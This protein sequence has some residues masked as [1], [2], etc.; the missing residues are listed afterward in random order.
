MVRSIVNI[1]SGSL[2]GSIGPIGFIVD[3]LDTRS[4]ANIID[5]S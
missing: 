2:A 1:R 5:I 4:A 3:I